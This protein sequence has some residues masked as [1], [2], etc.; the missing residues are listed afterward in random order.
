M[1]VV[2]QRAGGE[3]VVMH[4]DVGRGMARHDQFAGE[5]LGINRA[6]RSGGRK[7]GRRG[8]ARAVEQGIFRPNAR[9]HH[10]DENAI[11]R[12]A[13]AAEIIPEL[14]RSDQGQA[15]VHV[16]VHD[17]VGIDRLDLRHASDRLGV[18]RRGPDGKAVE[19]RLEALVGC[20]AGRL[21]G[22]GRD[23]IGLA[24]F[25]VG[26]VG[27]G[28]RRAEVDFGASRALAFRS[29]QAGDAAFVFGHRRIGQFDNQTQPAIGRLDRSRLHRDGVREQGRGAERRRFGGSGAQKPN[30]GRKQRGDDCELPSH[31]E[32]PG[33][34]CR[35]G[36]A[37]GALQ[38][39]V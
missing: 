25:Q 39:D 11:A 33:I 14:R 24:P 32:P 21:R 35:P 29:F 6:V 19:Y 8:V 20:R 3:F 22:H 2:V 28:L 38:P 31:G 4:R 16:G 27:L 23:E 12:R 36:M 10:G 1:A 26:G 37:V 15:G 7:A 17:L 18:L 13:L 5:E 30:G 34:M 9:V